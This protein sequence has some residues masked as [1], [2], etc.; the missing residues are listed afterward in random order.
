MKEVKVE[1]GFRAV[2]VDLDQQ[3]S[4][5]ELHFRSET[6]QPT[7]N[8]S[9]SLGVAISRM[10]FAGLSYGGSP[11]ERLRVYLAIRFPWLR[12]DPSD[13]SFLSSY[14]VVLANSE[15]TRGYIERWWERPSDVLFPPIATDRLHP[16]ENR[17]KLIL[18]VGRFFAPGLGHAK[19]QLEMV[20]WFGELYRAGQL[21]GWRMAVV[22]GC[23]RSQL[24]YLAKVREAA[25]GLPVEIHANAPRPL[26]EELLTTA[27]IFWAATGH[28]ERD[29]QPWAAE[30]FG[31]TTVEAMAGGCVPIVIDKAGQRE[32][33]TQGVDGFRWLSPE[34][35]K[36]QTRRVAGDEELRTKL[37]RAAVN[38]AAEFSEQAFADRWRHI[39]AAKRLV[40]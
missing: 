8:D 12:N 22:G 30:H 34:E 26:V 16:A 37:S 7:A 23:E 9:R 36:A 17:D 4:G 38:R 14:D 40:E 24:P 20:R 6:F 35:L 11:I 3:S 21:P 27:A 18:T 19:R 28:G 29:D 1:Q 2:T 10:R 15:Y 31:M 5:I 33:I 39:A 25:E 32:I 13:V